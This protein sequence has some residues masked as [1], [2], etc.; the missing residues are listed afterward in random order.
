MKR[1]LVKKKGMIKQK[2]KNPLVRR[3][4]ERWFDKGYDGGWNW[5]Y[6]T[7][8]KKANL[9]S[10]LTDSGMHA[11]V[12]DL[13]FACSLIESATPGHYHLY[14]DKEISWKDYKDVLKAMQKAGLVNK[15]WANEAIS[16]ERSCVRLPA[17]EVKMRFGELDRDSRVA[18]EIP[19]APPI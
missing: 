16:Q 19:S 13:D 11:P 17:L 9:V 2:P 8:P 12:I 6:A 5:R 18:S 4:V 7:D 3:V 10:S 15:G 1:L 14:L